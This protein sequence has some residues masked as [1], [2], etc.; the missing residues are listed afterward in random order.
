M[1]CCAPAA[2]A[3]HGR[4]ADAIAMSDPG[5]VVDFVLVDPPFGECRC[6]TCRDTGL[7]EVSEPIA[8]PAQI[9]ERAPTARDALEWGAWMLKCRLC[10]CTGPGP[11]QGGGRK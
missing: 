10:E 8:P 7:V 5:V 2:A 9:G 3:E 6:L 1:V 4:Q 11:A